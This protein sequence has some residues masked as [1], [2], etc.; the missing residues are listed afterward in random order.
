MSIQFA[1]IETTGDDAAIQLS[2]LISGSAASMTIKLLNTANPASGVVNV[3][4]VHRDEGGGLASGEGFFL[5]PGAP[6]L[7]ITCDPT[8]LWVS[9]HGEGEFV[10][11]IAVS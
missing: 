6:T 2:T 4:T 10:Q 8:D 1:V 3:A 7:T 9:V 5:T 11:I